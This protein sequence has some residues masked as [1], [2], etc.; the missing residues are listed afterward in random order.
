MLRRHG[1]TISLIAAAPS[2][3]ILIVHSPIHTV[4]TQPRLEVIP[5]SPRAAAM[6]EKGAAANEDVQFVQVV[7]LVSGGFVAKG[8]L[9]QN[10]MRGGLAGVL[11]GDAVIGAVVENGVTGDIE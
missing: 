10:D 9:A 8:A 3:V 4:S 11:D 5:R 1:S 7:G 2:V 6:T